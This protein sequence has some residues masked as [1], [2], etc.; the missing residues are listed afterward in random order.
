[1]AFESKDE[2]AERHNAQRQQG[3]QKSPVGR[4]EN[5]EWDKDGMKEEVNSFGDGTLVNWSE[6]ARRYGVKN[7]TGQMAQNGGQIAMEWL[8]SEGVDVERFKKRRRESDIGNIRKKMKKSVGGEITVPCPESSRK[9]QA[10]LKE[11]ILSGEVNVGELIVPRKVNG[12]KS[13]HTTKI[14]YTQ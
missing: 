7:K 8:K 3:K 6:L 14:V 11:K 4:F 2:A 12:N 13:L 5:M 9:L 1:M 10:K